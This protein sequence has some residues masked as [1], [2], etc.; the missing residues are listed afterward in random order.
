MP[1]CRQDKEKKNCIFTIW[2][3]PN[4]RTPSPFMKF[5]ILV[6]FSL[7]II[8]IL[9]VCLIYTV[10]ALL[11]LNMINDRIGYTHDRIGYMINAKA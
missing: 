5:T 4:T 1:Q 2:P 6:D 11:N 10:P 7:V 8:T 3:C 9:T